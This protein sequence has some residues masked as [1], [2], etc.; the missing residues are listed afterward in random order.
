MNV[1]AY[2]CNFKSFAYNYLLC[3]ILTIQTGRR[4]SWINILVE[5]WNRWNWNKIGTVLWIIKFIFNSS[6]WSKKISMIQDRDTTFLSQVS[7][8]SFLLENL[9]TINCSQDQDTKRQTSWDKRPEGF[10]FGSPVNTGTFLSFLPKTICLGNRH[11]FLDH[12]STAVR[13]L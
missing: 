6:T 13:L 7:Y 1:L 3:L 12:K 9:N 10:G 2:L 11:V 5:N 8:F 4:K